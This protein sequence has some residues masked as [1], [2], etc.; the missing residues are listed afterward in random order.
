MRPAAVN[1]EAFVSKSTRECQT[2]CWDVCKREHAT[3][4]AAGVTPSARFPQH[5][6]H[7]I[8]SAYTSLAAAYSFTK[9]CGSCYS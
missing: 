4:L 3:N 5:T 7:H 6:G 8:G 9:T 2:T 1:L